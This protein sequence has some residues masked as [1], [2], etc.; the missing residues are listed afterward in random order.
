[1]NFLAH[2]Y[3]SFNQPEIL[4]GNIISDFVKG[5]AKFNYP[6]NIQ[7]GITLHRAI[8]DFTDNHPA[9]KAAKEFF[10]PVYRLYS[11]A[12]IDVV[13]D[14]FLA[15]DENEFKNEAALKSFSHQVYNTLDDYYVL[16][17]QRFQNV[18]PHMKEHDW[19]FNYRTKSGTYKSFGGLV[20]R[21]AYITESASAILIFEENYIQL[22]KYY[23]SFFPDLKKFSLHFLTNQPLI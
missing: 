21:A 12:F 7:K 17:P 10:R 16:L 14:H 5:K 3:L 20:H 8:D 6:V 1:M 9:T 22:K 13:Y 23:N 4:I 11:G 15:S 19:L 2:A 18:L